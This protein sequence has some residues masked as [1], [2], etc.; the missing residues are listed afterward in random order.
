MCPCL[1]CCANRVRECA[2]SGSTILRGGATGALCVCPQGVRVRQAG[3]HTSTPAGG[4]IVPFN[5]PDIGEGIAEV[6]VREWFVKVGD[7]VE[8]FDNLLR[9]E[10]D[11][12]RR[13]VQC[14]KPAFPN[15]GPLALHRPLWRS[16]LGMRA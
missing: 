3:L 14:S 2:L 6:E 4:N 16:L 1:R 8:E 10:S 11:K 9:V 12:V 5:L 7:K 15:T 13:Q